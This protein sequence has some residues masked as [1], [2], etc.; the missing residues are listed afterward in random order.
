MLQRLAMAG[1]DAAL[2]RGLTEVANQNAN[3][4]DPIDLSTP[5]TTTMV[6]GPDGI[7]R[8]TDSVFGLPYNAAKMME[9]SPQFYNLA[10]EVQAEVQML[11]ADNVLTSPEQVDAFVAQKLSEQQVADMAK[12]DANRAQA[13]TKAREMSPEQ[14]ARL[15]ALRGRINDTPSSGMLYQR[16]EW[17]GGLGN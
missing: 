4:L 17:A 13:T 1:D 10:P 8:E 3:P 7:E 9:G 2:T 15:E 11:V 5:R 6:T 12:A 14:A 16:P